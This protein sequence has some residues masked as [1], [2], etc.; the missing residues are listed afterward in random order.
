MSI[1]DRI[2]QLSRLILVILLIAIL[3]WIGK[4]RAGDSPIESA[5]GDGAPLILVAR[6]ELHNAFYGASILIAKPLGDGRYIGFALNRPTG[7][8]LGKLF[9]EHGPSQKVP[10]PVYLGGPSNTDFIFALVQ[11]TENPGGES[12]QI[13][14]D[15]FVAVDAKTVDHIIEADP[16]HAR[17]FA[18]PGVRASC[19]MKS[20]AA[21]GTWR[22]RT[23]IWSCENP[24]TACG[25]NWSSAPR[26]ERT[27][28]SAPASRSQIARGTP[29][30]GIG[31]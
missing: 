17:F 16:S 6:P 15:L 28:S 8:T 5:S 20:S 3:G 9:P 4:T 18:G 30:A 26:C 27:P 11:S 12:M 14:Q 19:R 1:E 13:A 23:P 2:E 22:N 29:H 24:P 25:K 21:S 31:H 10:D 7:M